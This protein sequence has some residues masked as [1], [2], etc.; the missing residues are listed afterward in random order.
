MSHDPRD[1]DETIPRDDGGRCGEPEAASVSA[2]ASTA[3][4]QV[5]TT[6]TT[7]AA[8]A[9]RASWARAASGWSTWPATISCSGTSPSR[10]RT[11]KLTSR[12]ADA[13]AYLAEAR[14]LARLDHPHIV[15]VHDVGSTDEFP[16]FIVSKYIDGTNLA[17]T[18]ASNPVCRTPRRRS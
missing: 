1:P 3:Q 13:E 14:T 15:P 18:D 12:P 6:P 10:C 16:C 11:A 2:S 8:T 4:R 5:R 9:S 7:S 17:A